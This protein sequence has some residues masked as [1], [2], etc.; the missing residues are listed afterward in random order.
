MARLIKVVYYV[1]SYDWL[2]YT[3]TY[4]YLL[5]I[6]VYTYIIGMENIL[7]RMYIMNIYTCVHS[8]AHNEIKFKCE[9]W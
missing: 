1:A 3:H 4:I 6:F 8:K 9:I 2:M 7:I 5:Y